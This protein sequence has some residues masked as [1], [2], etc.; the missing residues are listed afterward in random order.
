LLLLHQIR[1]YIGQWS[2]ESGKILVLKKEGQEIIADLYINSSLV[3]AERRLFR[4]G[5]SPSLQM[6]TYVEGSALIVELADEGIGA[7]LQLVYGK[8]GGREFLVPTVLHGLHNDLDVHFG[9]PWIFPLSM[10][11][12]A[13]GK[14]GTVR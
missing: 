5:K 14:S 4:G 2:D 3:P 12:K 7:I 8:S 1:Q 6:K 9:V 13:G 10:Y 11:Y